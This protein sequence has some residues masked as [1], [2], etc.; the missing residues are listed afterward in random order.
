MT[1]VSGISRLAAIACVSLVVGAVAARPDDPPPKAPAELQGCWKLVS[2]ETDGTTNDPLGG[3]Q[4]RWVIKD[5]KILY[6]GE[7]I[8][9]FTTD[10]STTPRI[11]DLKFSAP[12]R[13]YEGI[14]VVEKDKLKVCLN[15]RTEGV[16]DRPGTFST[17]DQADWVLLVF[18]HE[19]AAPAKATEGLRAYAGIV[20][21]IDDEKKAIVINTPLKGSPADKAGL[22][23]DDVIRKVGA[24]E[25][26]D[27]QTVVKTVQ[28]AKPGEKL[29]FHITRDGKEQT[30]TVTVGVLPFHWA[31]GLN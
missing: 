30:V 14:Y 18:E 2:V 6:G 31:A 11:I 29:E 1:R 3:G 26:T 24:T 7:E 23:K 9:Q 20:L 19:K 17:K 5:N 27:L 22:K 15:K 8:I 10:P 16:K 12:E 25:A 28:N 4:P 21:S 13:V